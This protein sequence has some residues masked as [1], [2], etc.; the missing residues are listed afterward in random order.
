MMNNNKN[1]S[2]IDLYHRLYEIEY[3]LL[4]IETKIQ[5]V[6]KQIDIH[7]EFQNSFQKQIDTTISLKEVYENEM[8][9]INEKI[10]VLGSVVNE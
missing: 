8:K 3:I 4:G 6:K 10:N 7:P 2:R 5:N 9:D 1:V